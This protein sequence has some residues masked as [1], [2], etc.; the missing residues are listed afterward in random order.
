MIT[1]IIF[2]SEQFYS[3]FKKALSRN[4]LLE[5]SEETQMDNNKAGVMLYAVAIM[6]RS[7]L[8]LGRGFNATL[9]AENVSRIESEPVTVCVTSEVPTMKDPT[10]H[11][12]IITPLFNT[13]LPYRD[14]CDSHL[15]RTNKWDF[16]IEVGEDQKLHAVS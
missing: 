13:G 12:P 5:P 15:L 1:Q 16:H 10:L 9:S 6:H 14:H 3:D 4:K 8:K 11:R 2:S 7:T